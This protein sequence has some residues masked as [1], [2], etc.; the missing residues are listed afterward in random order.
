M[1]MPNFSS[2]SKI[3]SL[4]ESL[5]AIIAS[6]AMEEMAL[7][8]V[9]NAEGEK[10]KYIIDYVESQGYENA[11][12]DALL[13]VNNSVADVL[14]SI[15]KLQAILKEK[16]DAATSAIPP[17]GPSPR[18]LP[19]EIHKC[20]FETGPGNFLA[21]GA[22]LPFSEACK[23]NCDATVIRCNGESRILLPSGKKYEI[24]FELEAVN[25]H[26]SPAE[27]IAEFRNNEEIIREEVFVQKSTGAKISGKISHCVPP[28]YAC[29][30]VA[31]RLV[32]PALLSCVSGKVCM[33]PCMQPC[34]HPQV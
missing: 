28:E 31:F 19:E 21:R 22:S 7:S 10:I 12:T 27:F 2:I 24:S 30:T 11:D 5:S 33:Q 32:S 13:A 4:D 29:A 8:H 23:N 25:K 1:S 15:V 18:P 17:P 34:I 16:L 20:C 6:I 14:E 9:I 26:Q 3:P